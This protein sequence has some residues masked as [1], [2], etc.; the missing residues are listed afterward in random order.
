MMNETGG[1]AG[2]YVRLVNEAG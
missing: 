1:A 2:S